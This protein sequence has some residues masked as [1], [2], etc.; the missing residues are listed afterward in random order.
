MSQDQRAVQS[1]TDDLAHLSLSVADT[2]EDSFAVDNLISPTDNSI[3]RHRLLDPSGRHQ[4]GSASFFD[5]LLYMRVLPSVINSI[6]AAEPISPKADNIPTL[7]AILA[8]GREQTKLLVETV[9]VKQRDRTPKQKQPRPTNLKSSVPTSNVPKLPVAVYRF[10]QENSVKHVPLPISK[11]YR[12]IAFRKSP[13]GPTP[14]TEYI[15][16]NVLEHYRICHSLMFKT[17]QPDGAEG[18]LLVI[19]PHSEDARVDAKFLEAKL[20]LSEVTRMSLTSIEKEFGF[21]TFVCPPFGHEFSPKTHALPP[22][23][24]KIFTTVIDSSLA[25]PARRDCVF[26]LGVV[27]LKLTPAELLRLSQKLNWI[28]IEGLVAVS[29]TG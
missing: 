20:G 11:S 5:P 1:L 7:D 15:R 2:A 6:E 26:D 4:I 18:R 12:S 19:V 9:S 17:V 21:P 8:A 10:C 29:G 25:I 24:R 23:E 14:W 13:E 28:V 27:A 16:S 3:K 22:S